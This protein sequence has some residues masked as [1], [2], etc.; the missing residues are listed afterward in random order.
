MKNLLV[1]NKTRI[2]SIDIAKAIGIFLIVLGHT[3]KFGEL[4]KFIYAFHVPLF[5]FLSGLC[6]SKKSNSIFI[7]K[8]L[9]TIYLPYLIF[10]LISISIYS[11]LGKYI[12]QTDLNLF[13]NLKGM[14][15]AN[16]NLD[17][18]QWNQPLWFLP[19]LMIQLILIN[20]FENIITKRKNKKN[21]RIFIIMLCS[22]LGYILAFYKIY[23]PLQLEAALCMIIFT[24]IGIFI[25][26]NKDKI[27]KNKIINKI[28]NNKLATLIL[29]I[30]SIII[31][32]I[33]VKNNITISVMQDKYGNYLIYFIAAT[34]LIAD[35]M[36]ISKFID[37]LVKKQK[38]LSYIGQ[39]TL[40]ILLLHKFPILFFQELCPIINNI[41]NK[42]DTII[43]NII[44]III[45]IIV[46]GICVFIKFIINLIVLRSKKYDTN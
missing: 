5:F 22:V 27:L 10:A 4:R 3:L 15:Y 38:L 43:N 16:P 18:M 33:L 21:I 12:G 25:K 7:K 23:L 39:N 6:F 8:K 20:F 13:D 24:Y 28:K 41:L 14:V 26:G 40:F 2:K 45:S 42:Q 44:G 36:I 37:G 46:I 19:C 17:N 31:S 11:I 32:I 29:F 35:T 1:K 34:F 9:L 30:I